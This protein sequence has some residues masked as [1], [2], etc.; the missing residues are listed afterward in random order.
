MRRLFLL[1]VLA[2]SAGWAG[3]EP[4]AR[5]VERFENDK[6]WDHASG[7]WTVRDGRLVQDSPGGVPLTF[8][9]GIE[10]TDHYAVEVDARKRAGAEG[11]FLIFVYHGKCVWWNIGGWNNTYSMVERVPGT[12]TGLKVETGRLYHIKVV[13]NRSVCEGWIDGR[14]EFRVEL[15]AERVTERIAGT[16]GLGT[17]RTR[18]E[19]D[20]FQVTVYPG[21]PQRPLGE[22]L[23]DERRVVWAHEQKVSARS[24]EALLAECEAIVARNADVPPD[25]ARR[26]AALWAAPDAATARALKS[27]C[28]LAELRGLPPVAFITRYP[29]ERPF[30][31]GTYPSWDIV[32]RWGCSIRVCDPSRPD[33]RPRTI[34]RDRR[35]TIF[36]MNL[37]YDAKALFFSFKR[38]GDSYHLY[39]IGVD[40]SGLRQI[41]EGPYHDVHPLLLPDGRLLFVSTRVGSYALCQPGAATAMFVCDRDGSNIQRISANTLQDHSPQML[42]DGR[43]LF[44]RWEYV[45]RTLTWRQGLWT[46]NPDGTRLQLFFGNTIRDPAVFWQARPIPGRRDVVATFAPHH[47]W[48]HGAIG[49][50]SNYNGLESRRDVGFRWITRE[51]PRIADKSFRWSYRDPFPIN[52]HAFLVAYGNATPGRFGIYVLDDRDNKELVV[53]DPT[54]SCYNPLLLRPTAPPP[55]VAPHRRD[56]RPAGTYLL[57]DVYQGLSGVRRGE[58]KA[59]QIMEQVPK[60]PNMRGQRA[61]DMDPLIGR[62]TYYVKKC[63]GTVPVEADGSAY[64][65]APAL[66]EIYFQALDAS[67]KEIQRMGSATQLMP[68]ERQSCIGCHEGREQAPPN[69]TPLALQR[70]P[71]KP[72]PPAWGNDG[73]IDFVRVVQ[74]VFDRHCIKCHSGKDPKKGLDLSGDKTR[75]FNMA[76]NSLVDRGLV[77]YMW[78][79]RAPTKTLPPRSTGAQVSKLLQRIDSDHC[80]HLLP[81][82]DRRRVY[83]WIDANVPYYGTYEHTRPGK[84]GCRDLWA[85]P[86][87]ARQFAPVY[88]RRCG[89]C[90]KQ[91]LAHA[92]P[93]VRGSRPSPAHRWVNLSRPALSRVLTAPLAKAAGGL[94]LCHPKGKQKAPVFPTTSDPDYVAMLKAIEAGR[95]AVQANPRV[96]MPGAKPQPY[97]RE[98]GRVFTGFAGP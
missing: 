87:Y 31:L 72:E 57:V 10:L 73:L 3:E 46:M 8:F 42:P 44:T 45:D 58:V 37:S 13:V 33:A 39:E 1:C 85:E 74:P 14:R 82:E 17:C 29:F 75:Y 41:T 59:I 98:F 60:W 12:R 88:E 91:R 18:V 21:T 50:I 92:V 38:R 43:V 86:W 5:A 84:S 80:G 97:Y 61:H 51:F 69:I 70:P 20:N 55:A 26:L 6:A 2:T 53:S 71:S 16:L 34:F 90:H 81:P 89:G 67:G 47:G 56:R 4:R 23:A 54:M 77:H 11:F 49:T 19:Y 7:D 36:D 40:G 78:L 94:G 9:D 65:E 28:L 25:L 66:K 15:P 27:E 68:G 30:G 35:G 22:S 63:W 48:P 83:V 96:D 32:R 62:G 64:F 79:L 95:D 24:R 52:D 76:Y 93:P